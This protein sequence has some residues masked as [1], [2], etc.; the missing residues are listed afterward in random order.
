[1]SKKKETLIKNDIKNAIKRELHELIVLY[2][3]IHECE[4]SVDIKID[5]KL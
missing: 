5:I 1:M 4:I 3:G 2:S